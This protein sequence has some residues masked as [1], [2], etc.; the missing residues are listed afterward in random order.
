VLNSALAAIVYA[1]RD[2]DEDKTYGEKYKAEFFEGLIDAPFSML[3]YIKDIYSMA[4]GFTPKR[5]EMQLINDLYNRLKK[6]SF[7]KPLSYVR[8]AEALATFR[9]IPLKNINR[10]IEAIFDTSVNALRNAGIIDDPKA[11]PAKA[12]ELAKEKY[13]IHK[14][15]ANGS[16]NA[17]V[18]SV[19]YD[20]AY[21]AKEKGDKATYDSVKRYLLN[22]G[23]KASSFE[24]AMQN[25]EVKLLKEDERI[26][27]AAQA[28]I[29]KDF[30]GRMEILKQFIAEGHKKDTVIKAISEEVS[31]LHKENAPTPEE[32]IEAYKTGN[33]SKWYP[34]YNRLKLA[35]WS[36]NDIIALIK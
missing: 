26:A 21:A 18:S 10:D 31:R 33:K 23:R 14:R 16:V 32:F 34:I 9:G 27:E 28:E 8:V 36:H 35:G 13:D 15:D 4:R 19:F 2:D 5:P 1:M 3:P 30:H 17:A 29:D 12:F 6:F 22:G 20:I 25:R 24:N 11:D 7:D